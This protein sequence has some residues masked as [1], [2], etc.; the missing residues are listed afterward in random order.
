MG[1]LQAL[2]VLKQITGIGEDLAGRILI[3]DTLAARFRTISL[4]PDPACRLCGTHP[5]ITGIGQA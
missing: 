2:E 4:S 3:A 5:Q 1:S